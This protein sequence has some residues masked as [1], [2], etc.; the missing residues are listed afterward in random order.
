MA[1]HF[2]EQALV[3]RPFRTA[4]RG[5]EDIGAVA[6]QRQHALVAN[7]D[8]FFL[9]R[10]F[11]DDGVFVELPVTGVEDAPVRG[12]DQQ[13]IAFG[14]RMRERDIGHL[15]RADG[16][17]AVVLFDDMQ[18]DLVDQTRFLELAADEVGGERRGI[19]RHAEIGGEI[20]DRTD[21]VFMRMR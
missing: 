3:D 11:A 15:E 7:R 6:D 8:Q 18:L 13:R 5:I 14:D 9:G 17:L 20:G 19:D 10:R 21:V 16:E 2:L 12:I 1:L 4:R